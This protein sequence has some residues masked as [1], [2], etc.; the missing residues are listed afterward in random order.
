MT[1]ALGDFDPVLLAKRVVLSPP[2]LEQTRRFLP[3]QGSRARR[4]LEQV[5]PLVHRSNGDSR[6]DALVDLLAAVWTRTPEE[7][8]LVAAQDNLTVDYL[9]ALVQARLPE[10]GPIGGRVPLIAARVRQG[11]ET[12]AVED[13]GGFGNETSENLEAF[14]RGE[15]QIL[16]A[17]EA[18][19]V[20][21][22]LQC[23]RV[24]VLYSVPWRPEEVE[25]WIGR[26]DRIGNVA[27]FSTDGGA[28]TIDVYTIAQRGLVDEKVVGVLRRFGAFERSVN[29]DGAHLAEVAQAI[30]DAAL[31]PDA[32]SWRVLEER[33]ASM[34][35]EDAVQ[36]LSSALRPHL[37]WQV[38]WA[39]AQRERLDAMRP[40]APVIGDLPEHS[41]VGPKAWDR[42]IEPM[43]RL[44]EKTG[45]YHL[46]WNIDPD[47]RKRFRTLWYR[48]GERVYGH[49]PVTASVVFSFGADP[50]HERSPRHAHAFITRRGDIGTPPR[51]DVLMEVE[52]DSVR[53]PLRFVNFG[54][55]L[56]DELIDGWA[57]RQ[58]E[59]HLLDVTYPADHDLWKHA[60][61]GWFLLRLSAL[62]PADALAATRV[63]EE[64]LHAV[65]AAVTRSASEHLAPL[66][67]PFAAA[68]M[69]SL[70]AD[71][72]WLRA[73][74]MATS[75]LTARWRSAR[76]WQPIAEQAVVALG[77]PMVRGR[78]NL[79]RAVAAVDLEVTAGAELDRMRSS[80]RGGAEVWSSERPEFAAEL[81]A[82]LRIVAE[83]AR[84]ALDLAT[85]ALSRA[86]AA[87]VDA[88]V[89]G[90]R[91]QV[92]RAENLR[93][94]AID[95]VAMTEVYW[96]K[97]EAWLRA[98]EAAIVALRPRER[99][100]AVI[101]ARRGAT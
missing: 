76:G 2:S 35:A 11:M 21:L 44:L 87:E 69:C 78:D 40:V 28:R 9:F 47:T 53:R 79:P 63:R 25:Q 92:T 6:A 42:A 27:A 13:L 22:N 16:F 70:E 77:N 20:G 59:Q 36:E 5:K 45:D 84:D 66:V 85:R 29:L 95:V 74:L 18:A 96:Q 12:D 71:E 57:G 73:S 72:R 17:P 83:E 23:A 67:A 98:C 61:P 39:T 81:R 48:F 26:L 4:L 31:R 51:R 88:H 94:A 56:H 93:D 65:A 38:H 54:D 43:L 15:A 60:E 46:R 82:R 1:S 8:V 80:E 86:E 10:I 55:A 24:L 50:A 97:R 90:N 33:T 34:A 101:R 3:P 19:Q 32:V 30:E 58:P 68:A 99:L 41:S 75:V 62:D 52:Q 37:P 100:V 14:Q 49:R 91:A 7:R 89:R 64:T